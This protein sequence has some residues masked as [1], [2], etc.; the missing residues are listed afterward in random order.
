[1]GITTT[2]SMKTLL[3]ALFAT[4]A[5][6]VAMPNNLDTIDD[7]NHDSFLQMQ[8]LAK[9]Q[10]ANACLS[11]AKATEDEVK[12]N[13]QV[14]QKTLDQ[15]DKGENCP[16]KGSAAV[17][18]STKAKVEAQS[19]LA[20]ANKRKKDADEEKLQFPT[21]QADSLDGSTCSLFYKSQVWKTS[22]AKRNAAS[23]AADKAKGAL[24]SASQ[25][26]DADVI[27]AKKAVT[28]CQCDVRKLHATSLKKANADA[29]KANTKAWTKAAH[30]RCVLEGKNA[31]QC[32]VPDVPKVKKV[33]VKDGVKNAN[34]NPEKLVIDKC[35]GVRYCRGNSDGQKMLFQ[36]YQKN[37]WEK[38]RKYICPDGFYWASSSQYRSALASV[39]QCFAGAPKSSYSYYNQC[40]WSGYN[41]PSG[42]YHTYFR[43]TDSASNG[44]YQN[45]GSAMS[46]VCNNDQ[47]TGH[48][49]G[50]VCLKRGWSTPGGNTNPTTQ[51]TWGK[52]N[53]TKC[54]LDFKC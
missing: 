33:S 12:K 53:P 32:T 8:E 48:F 9:K 10:G 14:L 44:C 23:Q 21:Y 17:A 5:F 35:N 43:F 34:C 42:T 6:A 7:D 20:A 47:S 15:I 41:D 28:S 39:G 45:V 40:G 36:T 25:A 31:N 50:I 37:T 16:S 22:K 1:M 29:V 52:A 4:A 46:L 49:A 24:A 2:R 26:L 19:S 13:V 54:S 30:L 38:S 18:S 11:L 27:A 3:V 51:K